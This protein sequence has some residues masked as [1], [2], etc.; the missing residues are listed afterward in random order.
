MLKSP[1]LCKTKVHWV[2]SYFADLLNKPFPSEVNR[3]RWTLA[4]NKDAM[5]RW[6]KCWKRCT[7]KEKPR[8]PNNPFIRYGVAKFL[9]IKYRLIFE[10]MCKDRMGVHQRKSLPF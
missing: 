4:V 1:P 6:R 5:L 3:L 10:Q 2:K 9:K 7:P 8:R